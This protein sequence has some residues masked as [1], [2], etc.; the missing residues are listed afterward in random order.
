MISQSRI[1]QQLLKLIQ[2]IAFDDFKYIYIILVFY[3]LDKYCQFIFMISKEGQIYFFN[4][5]LKYIYIFV[6]LYVYT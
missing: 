4:L 2:L 6:Y 1:I 5:K 3:S